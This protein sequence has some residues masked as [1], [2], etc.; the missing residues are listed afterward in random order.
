MTYVYLATNGNGMTKIGRSAQPHR[1]I[2]SHVGYTLID[3]YNTGSHTRSVDVERYIIRTLKQWVVKGNEWFMIDESVNL[4]KTF[5][6]LIRKAEAVIASHEEMFLS[7]YN[8]QISEILKR[9]SKRKTVPDT[10]VRRANNYRGYLID[11]FDHDPECELFKNGELVISK[12]T[13]TPNRW[14]KVT[15]DEVE[16]SYS[17]VV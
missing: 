14:A 1:R 5:R 16:E 10:F 11:D 8:K 3:T 17:F 4:I 15:V 12:A 7:H 6:M 9:T 2:K 13:I